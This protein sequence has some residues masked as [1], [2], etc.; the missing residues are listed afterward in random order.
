MECTGTD[1]PMRNAGS[2]IRKRIKP[3]QITDSHIPMN[4]I[5]PRPPFVVFHPLVESPP[6]LQKERIVSDGV[7]VR[8]LGPDNAAENYF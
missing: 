2:L 4:F 5:G 7:Q 6:V 3:L 8:Q 1:G